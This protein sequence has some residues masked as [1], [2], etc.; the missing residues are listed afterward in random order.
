MIK[1]IIV[2]D[3]PAVARII[4][5]FVEKERLP[6]EIVGIAQNGIEALELIRNKDVQLVFLDIHMPFMDGFKVIE[7]Q[8]DKSYIIITAHDSFEYAQQA[9][10]LGAKDII[11]KPIEYKQ[12]MKS[13]ARAIGWNFTD[14]PTL[15]A[16]LEYINKYYQ[17]KIDLTLLSNIFYI[18]PSQ[19]SRLFNKYMDTN[20]ISY[21][22]EVRIKKAIELL[23]DENFGIKEVAEKVGYG[24]L[25]NFYKYF[26][27]NTGVTPAVYI[28]G[29]K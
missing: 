21:I 1:A 13:I 11:L 15:N 17:E 25:N 8:P 3:E 24:S 22:H 4:S 20:T 26:K 27:L 2:D 9:L 5:H 29:N 23:K 7:N 18:S 28:Q 12:L 6:I 14:N 10:R 19:I 16:I